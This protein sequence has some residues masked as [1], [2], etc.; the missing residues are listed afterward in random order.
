[1]SNKNMNPIFSL[2]NFRSFG[3]DGA[4]FEIAPITVL[5]GCNSAGKSSLV[6]AM[7]LLSNQLIDETWSKANDRLRP[8]FRFKTTS[9]ELNLGGFRN[10]LNDRSKDGK[11]LIA[12]KIWSDYLQ[13]EVVCK[14][15]FRTKKNLLK[16]GFL[17]DFTIEKTDGTIIYNPSINIYRDTLLIAGE[18]IDIENP[19]LEGGDYFDNIEKNYHNFV[20]ACSYVD[21]TEK[22]KNFNDKKDIEIIN[23]IE[24]FRSSLNLVKKQLGTISPSVYDSKIIYEWNNRWDTIFKPHSELERMYYKDRTKEEMEKDDRQLF[25]TLVINEIISPLF[26]QK[27]ISID[28]STNE[29]RRVY[30]FDNRGKLSKLLNMLIE[31]QQTPTYQSGPFVNYWLKEFKIGNSME[32]V[33]MSE[34]E[35][36]GVKVYINKNNSTRLLADEGYGITQ[37]ISIL[38]QIELSIKMNRSYDRMNDEYYFPDYYICIEEPEIHL[39]PDYQ[40]KLAAMFVEAYQKYNIH[41]IIETHSEY[42]IRKLQVMVADKENKLSSN[43]ISLNYVE[44]DENGVSHNRQ[45]KINDDGSLLGQF[46]SGFFDEAL[47]LAIKL[48]KSKNV[49]S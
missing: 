12:Y 25:F 14:R 22:I 24:E 34:E 15:V 9:N 40:S 47:N 21:L 46:G 18:P 42:L 43:D 32:I 13:E 11:M 28:S 30:N 16:E 37:L 44:K 7:E 48:Y 33:G 45:I 2:K 19:E 36:A 41:F 3:E 10:V 26:L 1:M 5:T 39:H 8:S 23:K 20:L 31:K 35:G 4:D 49:L 27:L 38:L 17:S 29:I 6:K